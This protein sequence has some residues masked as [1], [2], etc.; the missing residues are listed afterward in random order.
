MVPTDDGVGF[1]S[2]GADA[3]V[4]TGYLKFGETPLRAEILWQ[5]GSRAQRRLFVPFR[6]FDGE[7]VH[8]AVVARR[9]QQ[10][11]VRVEVQTGPP[12]KK[13]HIFSIRARR[14]KQ[15]LEEKGGGRP[16]IIE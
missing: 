6:I 13:N 5:E 12:I 3:L 11:R 15:K 9:A 10:R 14:I 2:K 4:S 7:D 1:V 8:R 16:Q